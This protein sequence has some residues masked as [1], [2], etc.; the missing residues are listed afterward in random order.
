MKSF[1]FNVFDQWKVLKFLKK[2]LNII[3]NESISM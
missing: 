2:W 3:E 1:N